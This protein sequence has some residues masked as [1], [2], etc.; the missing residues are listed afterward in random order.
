MGHLSNGYHWERFAPKI[1]NNLELRVEERIHLDIAVGLTVMEL[2]DFH[3][4][5]ETLKDIP[6][7]R[8]PGATEDQPKDI[9]V[10]IAE[11]GELLVHQMRPKAEALAAAWGPFVRLVGTHSIAGRAVATLG[12]YLLVGLG[13]VGVFNIVEIRQQVDNLNSIKGTRELFSDALSGGSSST[14]VQGSAPAS[15]PTA[16]P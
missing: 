1:G 9:N 2:V 11:L 3:R 14:G 8:T 7:G 12:D 6:I 16:G 13:Q 4:A 5:L 15:R 10:A